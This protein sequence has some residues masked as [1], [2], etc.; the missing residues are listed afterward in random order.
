[1]VSGG[2]TG[3]GHR[4]ARRRILP[5]DARCRTPLCPFALAANFQADKKRK[6]EMG[7]NLSV[8]TPAIE[9]SAE[10]AQRLWRSLRIP[11]ENAARKPLG[12]QAAKNPALSHF[13]DQRLGYRSIPYG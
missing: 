2:L 4:P 6:T 8:L 3:A 5:A 7:L 1:M 11:K 10:H 9:Q 12:K 13:V